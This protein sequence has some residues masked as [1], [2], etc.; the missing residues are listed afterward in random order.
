MESCKRLSTHL[1][2]G[3]L[4][5]GIEVGCEYAARLLASL[6]GL[7]QNDLL[8]RELHCKQAVALSHVAQDKNLH[9]ATLSWLAVT[10]YY[11]KHP[12]KALQTYQETLPDIGAA[13][14]YRLRMPSRNR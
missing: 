3:A 7:H 2:D 13:S 4:N 14:P 12:A 9:V 5:D 10:Y 11:S 1:G 6:I 8:Q